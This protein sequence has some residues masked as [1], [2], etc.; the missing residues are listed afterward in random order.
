LTDDADDGEDKMEMSARETG[1]R[2][3]DIAEENTVQWKGELRALNCLPPDRFC[4]A[5]DH[6]P[7]QIA[8]IRKL[9][10]KEFT[11]STSDGIYFD[12]SRFPRYA[13]FAGLDLAAQ[14][15]GDRIERS[16]EKRNAADFALW[17]FSPENA[18]RQLEWDSPWGRGFP[19]WHIE[20]SAMSSKYLGEQFDIHTGG[21]DHIP[22]HH[23]NE[24]AQS[25]CAFGVHPWVNFW[26][27]NAFY[28]FGG[29]KMSKSKGNVLVLDDLVA[30]GFE[31][32]SFR[33]FFLQ[34]AY[35]Q[36]QSFTLEALESAAT[37]YRRLLTHALEVRDVSGEGDPALQAPF[38]ERFRSAM[39]D[40]LNAPRAMAVVWEVVRN[41]DLPP[42]D[43]RDLLEAFDEILALD[44]KTA[45]PPQARRESDPRID[46][47]VAERQEARKRRDFAGADRIRD[48]LAAEGIE[49]HDTPEGSHW[50]R[51]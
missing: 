16:G 20:C 43:R 13:D 35:R 11:Y 49:V 19:G 39:R 1:R 22:V 14:E 24:I 47:L 31:A 25:E 28:D 10:E 41:Q 45:V 6:I 18:Q 8:L 3:E 40:D 5:T 27:H 34:A 15:A 50:S 42:A 17:K 23:P 33:Y 26:M 30:Q 12:V 4:K 44:L 48:A 37:G 9:E 32:L 21:M 7:E 2:I 36:P 38:L 29:L 51:K 46:A